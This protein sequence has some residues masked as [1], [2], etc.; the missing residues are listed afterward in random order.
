MIRGEKALLTAF[1]FAGLTSFI[2]SLCVSAWLRGNVLLS[3]ASG[4]ISFIVAFSI[5]V[6]VATK[7]GH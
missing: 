3:V 6:F 4:V 7:V 5:Y 1:G 2:V